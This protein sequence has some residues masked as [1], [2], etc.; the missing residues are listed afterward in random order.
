MNKWYTL[1]VAA[2]ITFNETPSWVLKT[3]YLSLIR[4]HAVLRNSNFD[5]SV[6]RMGETNNSEHHFHSI[7]QTAIWRKCWAQLPLS[8]QWTLPGDLW[9]HR[10]TLTQQDQTDCT[11][12]ILWE[13]I[14]LKI[15]WNMKHPR[16]EGSSEKYHL[17]NKNLEL[18]SC[19]YLS[20]R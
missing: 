4:T 7:F 14:V 9:E 16:S 20:L 10:H 19:L 6:L 11:S 13:W 3:L 5:V 8:C 12:M 1:Y 17:Q 15:M 2:Y 18:L